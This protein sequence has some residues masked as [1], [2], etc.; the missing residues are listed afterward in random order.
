MRHLFLLLIVIVLSL[1]LAGAAPAAE[2]SVVAGLQR[3][4]RELEAENASL[5]TQLRRAEKREAALKKW[6][7]AGT[8][9]VNPFLYPGAVDRERVE[10]WRQQVQAQQQQIAAK[11]EADRQR[12]RWLAR[13]LA[14]GRKSRTSSAPRKPLGERMA[15]ARAKRKRERDAR[16]N[17]TTKRGE[18]YR[19]P[20]VRSYRIPAP[21]KPEEEK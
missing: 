12:G 5:R 4:I 13:W 18:P 21:T 16:L 8:R 15:E 7:P 1:T 14:A 3:R 19:N 2:P 10:A 9:S 20:N 11:R 6:Q 17:R